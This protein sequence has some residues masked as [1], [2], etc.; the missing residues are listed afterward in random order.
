MK[1]IPNED[2]LKNSK[3]CNLVYWKCNI[4]PNETMEPVTNGKSIMGRGLFVVEGKDEANLI[5]QSSWVL[6]QFKLE[7]K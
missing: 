7:E 1:K 5:E 3:Q 4:S 6:S 2:M